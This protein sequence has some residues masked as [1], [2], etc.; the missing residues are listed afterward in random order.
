MNNNYLIPANAKKGTL[1]FNVFRPFDLI[2]FGGG[3]GLSLIILA[4]IPTSNIVMVLLACLP[5][6]ICSLLVVP[7][8]YYHNV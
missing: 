6:V 4:I 7:L 2:L 5:G 8:P 1:I 3:M